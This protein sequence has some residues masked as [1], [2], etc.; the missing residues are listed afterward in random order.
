MLLAGATTATWVSA[1]LEGLER[2]RAVLPPWSS[3]GTGR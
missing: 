2:T 3:T 1:L